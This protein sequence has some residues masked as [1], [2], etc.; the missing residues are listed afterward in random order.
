M[1]FQCKNRVL[2]VFL[3]CFHSKTM[4]N[5]SKNF[6]LRP[7]TEKAPPCFQ[8][9]KNKGG[10]FLVGGG[11]FGGNPLIARFICLHATLCR[12]TR[13]Q[14]IGCNTTRRSCLVFGRSNGIFRDSHKSRFLITRGC[15]ANYCPFI[16][17]RTISVLSS[18]FVVRNGTCIMMSCSSK[19]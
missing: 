16:R 3:K 2:G 1:V 18:R 4:Q 12:P 6:G 13:H 15:C 14:T 7:N 9:S 11:F 10:A 19:L 8:I 5:P 17:C